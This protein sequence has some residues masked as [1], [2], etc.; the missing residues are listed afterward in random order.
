MSDAT[1]HISVDR[2]D[3]ARGSAPNGDVDAVRASDSASSASCYLLFCDLTSKFHADDDKYHPILHRLLEALLA[4]EHS[5]GTSRMALR[6]LSK[7]LDAPIE[8]VLAATR[9]RSAQ[10]LLVLDEVDKP[11]TIAFPYAG[12]LEIIPTNAPTPPAQQPFVVAAQIKPFMGMGGDRFDPLTRALKFLAPANESVPFEALRA[13]LKMQ[14]GSVQTYL[15]DAVGARHIKKTHS[16]IASSSFTL[17]KKVQPLAQSRAAAAARPPVPASESASGIQPPIPASDGRFD[18]LY[19]AILTLH[20]SDNCVPYTKL[21]L[22]LLKQQ[23][24][25][26]L[27]GGSLEAYLRDAAAAGEISIVGL[28]I[29]D[30]SIELI[31][32]ERTLLYIKN[33]KRKRS[34]SPT[35]TRPIRTNLQAKSAVDIDTSSFG[36]DTTRTLPLEEIP[37]D[38]KQIIGHMHARSQHV[39][40]RTLR[41]HCDGS[42]AEVEQRLKRAHQLGLLVYGDD[43]NGAWVRLPKHAAAIGCALCSLG[44]Y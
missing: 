5:I 34:D 43:G 42:A 14:D 20:P 7:A 10:G 44:R 3:A 32:K 30:S 37:V 8:Y 16:K 25:R 4:E 31:R 39:T 12:P 19:K 22:H 38:L 29:S 18:P 26:A 21:L 23:R 28:N 15:S 40:V 9:L 35:G 13:M 1:A 27:L 24:T 33:R 2:P 11:K 17:A 6:A 36:V 41:K